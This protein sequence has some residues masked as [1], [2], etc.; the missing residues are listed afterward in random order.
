MGHRKISGHTKKVIKKKRMKNLTKW[1]SQSTKNYQKNHKLNEFGK[2]DNA[3][4]PAA[5]YSMERLHLGVL[6]DNAVAR[7]LFS[8]RNEKVKKKSKKS[9]KGFD[10]VSRDHRAACRV[11][12]RRQTDTGPLVLDAFCSFCRRR[13][14]L[15]RFWTLIQ[16]VSETASVSFRALPVSFPLLTIS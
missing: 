3:M 14:R 2:V 5:V 16:I 10:H 15:C 13:I 12:I 4:W 7:R 1:K 6:G 11:N 9:A 8:L